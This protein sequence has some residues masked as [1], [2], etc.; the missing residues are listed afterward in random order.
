MATTFF[1]PRVFWLRL[2]LTHSSEV[3]ELLLD[4]VNDHG[5]D[6]LVNVPTC[7]KNILDLFCSHPH[8]ITD[9]EVVPGISD[10]EA[11]LYCLNLSDKLLSDEA[12]HP[13]YLYH[14]GDI[15]SLKS[16]MSD[17]QTKFLTSYP[18][19]N[20][21]EENWQAL[22]NAIS[23]A[24]STHVPQRWS[25]AS[26]NLPWLNHTVKRRINLQ[27]HLYKRAKHLQTEEAWSKYRSIKNKNN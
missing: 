25:K 23:T 10:H 13:V 8:L 4:S 9:I 15:N 27:S 6:Q 20:N 3:S 17:F 5:L 19:S 24:I 18:Y 7:G 11:I 26:N 21:V 16:D 12:K 14:Q 22:K 1:T 2:V